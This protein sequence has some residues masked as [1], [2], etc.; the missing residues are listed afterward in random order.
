M[1]LS[2]VVLTAARLHTPTLAASTFGSLR[3]ATS[4]LESL[5]L[6][7]RYSNTAQKER[8]HTEFD[9]LNAALRFL[10]CLMR[11]TNNSEKESM[12][13]DRYL[14]QQRYAMLAAA[15][16]VLLHAFAIRAKSRSSVGK[17]ARR[18]ER[19]SIGGGGGG[20]GGGGNASDGEAMVLLEEELPPTSEDFMRLREV[21][22][23][24]ELLSAAAAVQAQHGV[25][26]PSVLPRRDGGEL[27]A[28]QRPTS[29]KVMW[30]GASQLQYWVH[31][32]DLRHLPP[33][34]PLDD[35]SASTPPP[36]RYFALGLVGSPANSPGSARSLLEVDGSEE[37]NNDA[38]EED[39]GDGYDDEEE[40]DKESRRGGSPRMTQKL[41]CGPTPS[42]F[43]STCRCSGAS[44]ESSPQISRTSL[45]GVISRPCQFIT[46]SSRHKSTG[47]LACSAPRA[48][49]NRRWQQ[50][51][52]W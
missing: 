22:S 45:F 26:L 37:G 20:G 8:L 32:G 13:N 3:A 50:R 23:E 15:S 47:A 39:H 46:A 6:V 5:C 34:F 16:A 17:G 10:D 12:A 33:G 43:A 40:D 25:R 52:I 2:S 31:Y 44:S 11:A 48:A 29:C 38:E 24:D 28:Q 41:D 7:L 51:A 42:S 4:C 18:R 14:A 1:A 9:S 49:T 30:P 27:A 35:P 36:E 21:T 19:S